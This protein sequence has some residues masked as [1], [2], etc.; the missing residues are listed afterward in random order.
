MLPRDPENLTSWLDKTWEGDCLEL[1]AK[2]PEASVDLILSDPPY[3]TTKNK[4][5]AII[6]LDRMWSEYE[7]VLKP[8]GVVL[9]T[10]AQPFSSLLVVS[11]PEW[12]RYEWVWRKTIGSGQLNIKHRPLVLHEVALVFSPNQPPYYPQMEEGKPYTVKRKSGEWSGGGYSDQKNHESVNKGVR[13][14]KSVITVPNPRI[15]GGHKTQKPV[16]LFEYFILTYTQPDAVILDNTMGSGTTGVAA[17][18]LGRH[19][20]GIEL[21]PEFVTKANKRTQHVRYGV[22]LPESFPRP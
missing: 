15:T 4:W 5:D 2:I 20:I 18:N 9:L 3:G 11:K 19:F 1:T 16:A 22:G 12:F 14:P 21:D 8:D 17:R 7:R 6:P 13:W 10:A